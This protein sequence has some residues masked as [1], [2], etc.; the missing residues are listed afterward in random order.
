[1]SKGIELE[2]YFAIGKKDRKYKDIVASFQTRDG[3]TIHFTIDHNFRG[4][5]IIELVS[6]PI[7]KKDSAED[8]RK[9]ATHVATLVSCMQKAIQASRSSTMGLGELG[10]IIKKNAN[11]TF[12]I[13]DKDFM[14]DCRKA[15]EYLKSGNQDMQAHLQVNFSVK[16]HDFFHQQTLSGMRLLLDEEIQYAE[17]K[18]SDD[19]IRLRKNL[20][21]AWLEGNRLVDENYYSLWMGTETRKLRKLRGV[22]CQATHA[23]KFFDDKDKVHIFEKDGYELLNKNPVTNQGNLG[24]KDINGILLKTASLYDEYLSKRDIVLYEYAD[25]MPQ[26]AKA[27]RM[28]MLMTRS[29]KR[30]ITTDRRNVDDTIEKKIENSNL[31]RN[32]V[33][34]TRSNRVGAIHFHK[35]DQIGGIIYDRMRKCALENMPD[36]LVAL[37]NEYLDRKQFTEAAGVFVDIYAVGSP[38][39]ALDMISGLKDK[40]CFLPLIKELKSMPFEYSCLTADDIGFTKTLLKIIYPEIGNVDDIYNAGIKRQ[41]GEILFEKSNENVVQKIRNLSDREILD[42]PSGINDLFVYYCDTGNLDA[43]SAINERCRKLEKKSGNYSE[44][45]ILFPNRFIHDDETPTYLAAKNGHVDVLQYILITNSKSTL[46]MIS[47]ALARYKSTKDQRIL[48]SFTSLCEKSFNDQNYSLFFNIAIHLIQLQEKGYAVRLEGGAEFA[49]VLGK[50]RFLS[51]LQKSIEISPDDPDQFY[52][53]DI[54]KLLMKINEYKSIEEFEQHYV[55]IVKLVNTIIISS[56][57]EK[58]PREVKGVRELIY[59]EIKGLIGSVFHETLRNGRVDAAADIFIYLYNQAPAE[60]AYQLL[61]QT[62]DSN[63]ITDKFKH[64]LKVKLQSGLKKFSYQSLVDIIFSKKLI[65]LLSDFDEVSNKDEIDKEFN[66]G[67][68]AVINQIINNQPY[69]LGA[70]SD[71]DLINDIFIL[72]CNNGNLTLL[73]QLCLRHGK[74]IVPDQYFYDSTTA[75]LAAKNGRTELLLFLLDS[76]PQQRK[77]IIQDIV[78]HHSENDGSIDCLTRLCVESFNARNYTV[79]FELM[80]YLIE[81]SRKN[82]KINLPYDNYSFLSAWNRLLLIT[83]VNQMP[84]FISHA[85]KTLD[86]IYP[87]NA[88]KEYAD[89]TDLI[90]DSAQ[91]AYV[92]QIHCL[93]IEKTVRESSSISYA[94]VFY[95]NSGQLYSQY[96]RQMDASSLFTYQ[97]I[98][99]YDLVYRIKS[100]IETY[101]ASGSVYSR[102]PHKSKAGEFL[103]KILKLANDNDRQNAKHLVAVEMLAFLQY[104]QD[105]SSAKLYKALSGVIYPVL[106]GVSAQAVD[107]QYADYKQSLSIFNSSKASTIPKDWQ[108]DASLGGFIHARSKQGYIECGGDY[109]I[110]T[111]NPI[112]VNEIKK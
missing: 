24:V 77:T 39:I 45:F 79:S 64:E 75:Y 51:R 97:H 80:N 89:L 71:G 13:H 42:D 90:R 78:N 17:Y 69:D 99:A 87:G 18:K 76:F 50:L 100:V 53:K 5:A 49:S 9:L 74:Q 38:K 44:R 48:D 85:D 28:I 7:P 112:L 101:P 30:A 14:F 31:L 105:H 110:S 62:L 20:T 26:L 95:S 88:M 22:Y 108:L 70:L 34:E 94:D 61:R 72:A 57:E 84:G 104:L 66:S 102:Y 15:K 10:E 68:P 1:M 65:A 35:L 83:S 55:E 81:F 52:L 92:L 106:Y 40:D 36:A 29:L 60:V 4:E 6:A 21:M 103:D 107:N 54:R 59:D 8:D 3:F 43:V 25:N 16:T 27:N 58:K 109:S 33:F 82:V 93:R 19:R 67:V 23:L 12:T 46:A 37:F 56:R 32:L 111:H 11:G 63:E 2:V 41:A 86:S 96:S 98:D 91:V 73:K 47:T